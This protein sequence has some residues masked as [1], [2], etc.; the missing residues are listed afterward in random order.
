MPGEI[1]L[2]MPDITEAEVSAVADVLRSGRL[3]MGPRTV[4]FEEMIAE[5]THRRHGVAVSSGTAGLHLLLEALGVGPGD[6]VITTP[7]S[8][9]ASANC[10]LYV[11]ATPIFVDINPMTLNLDPEKVE[12]AIT[13]RTKAI[14]AVETFGNP[15]DM[16]RIA[17]VAQRNEIPLIEDACEALGA[18]YKGRPVGSFGRAAVFAFY[19]NKQITTGE[20]GMIVTDDDRLADTCRS[21]RNQGRPLG[22]TPPEGSWLSHDRL[23]FNYRLSE[24]HAALG[25]AQMERLDA[26]LQRRREVAYMYIDKLMEYADLV[27]PGHHPDCDM[28]W[29]VFVVRLGDQFGQKE[30]DRI[31][32]GLRRHDVGAANYF[33]PIHLQPFYRQRFNFKPGDFPVTESIAS[34]TIALPFFNKLDTTQI[35][36]VCLT[37][38]V[39]LQREQL[40][41][42]NN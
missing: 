33:P 24:L 12:A 15:A 39:M 3:S 34:R 17:A 41:R 5:R 38:Q 28:S 36:L 4:R 37:L 1:P 7:F 21:L 10:I 18:N 11:G 25:I 35:E 32:T 19:P 40:L 29:F 31:I 20:G 23:G 30:R 6:E 8:F 9:V 16:D 2:S 26:I 22:P 14:I 42:P 13:P 27:L